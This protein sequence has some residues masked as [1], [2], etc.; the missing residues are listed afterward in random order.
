M[1]SK[2]VNYD[3]LKYA[4]QS[5]GQK[6]DFSQVKDPVVFFN[7]IKTREIVIEKAR[8]FTKRF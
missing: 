5:S 8:K 6:F 1:L 4:A 7:Y 3:D 2:K